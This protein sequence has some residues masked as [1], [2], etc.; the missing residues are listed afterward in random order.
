[1]DR[2]GAGSRSSRNAAKNAERSGT[3]RLDGCAKVKARSA[4]RS[5]HARRAPR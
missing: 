5:R 4:R 3:N 2:E 1:L